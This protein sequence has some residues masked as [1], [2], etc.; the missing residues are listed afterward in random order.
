[1][2]MSDAFLI[3]GKQ[4]RIYASSENYNIKMFMQIARKN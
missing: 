2:A 1:M 4:M 3:L